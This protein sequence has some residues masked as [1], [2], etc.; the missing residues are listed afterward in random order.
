MLKARVILPFEVEHR[1]GRTSESKRNCSV[2][3]RRNKAETGR[4]SGKAGI[5]SR[6]LGTSSVTALRTEVGDRRLFKLVM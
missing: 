3:L 2:G 1:R 6:L 4:A 5:S